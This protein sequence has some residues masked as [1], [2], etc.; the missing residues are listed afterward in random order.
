MNSALP[1]PTILNEWRPALIQLARS[2]GH[3]ILSIYTQAFSVST[4]ADQ[5]PLTQADLAS[6]AR[7]VA[8]LTQLNPSLVIVSEEGAER[9][10]PPHQPYWL[11]DPLDGTK[12]FINRNGEFTVNIA[13]IDQ[14]VPVLSVVGIPALNQWYSAVQHGGAFV[15]TG[16]EPERRLYTHRPARPALNVLASRSHRHPDLDAKLRAL[17]PL[18][19]VSAGS[20]LKF[21]RVADG[22]ADF[23]PRLG[24]THWWDSAA[25]Q[26][27][28]EEAGGLVVNRRGERLRYPHPNG[29]ISTLND[30]F[31]VL[32]DPQ[33]R[34][35]LSDF[36]L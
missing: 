3:D 10:V 24:P 34:H 7:I 25:G 36:W 31:L 14:Q 20:A 22:S 17:E 5:S 16:V 28:V 9:A 30:D 21:T 2:A 15:E 12:E 19:L 23:Y 32:G 6:H 1:S 8:G 13:L 35:R 4:K 26:L 18:Q 11:V 29:T 33:L 27:L